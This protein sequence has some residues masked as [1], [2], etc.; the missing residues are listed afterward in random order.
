MRRDVVAHNKGVMED[1]FM[2]PFV[3]EPQNIEQGI[4]N[5]E[6]SPSS[7]CGSLFD[8]ENIIISFRDAF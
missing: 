8:I 2:A 7:F 6:A 3:I 4:S 1:T 5:V